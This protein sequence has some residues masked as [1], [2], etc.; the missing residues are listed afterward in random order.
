[1][2]ERGEVTGSTRGGTGERQ[3]WRRLGY[4]RGLG[5]GG[6]SEIGP[7]EIGLPE[8]ELLGGR[9]AGGARVSDAHGRRTNL[10][11][12]Q[13]KK[14]QSPVSV[15]RD[16]GDRTLFLC[17]V[18]LFPTS[19]FSS[20]TRS[21]RT[22]ARRPLDDATTAAT[23]ARPVFK[24]TRLAPASFLIRFPHARL[25]IRRCLALCLALCLVVVFVPRSSCRID[26]GLRVFQT[27]P[28]ELCVGRMTR[29]LALAVLL[30]ASISF[31]T[32][33]AACVFF[34]IQGRR[35]PGRP[36]YS[37]PAAPPPRAQP[38]QKRLASGP[39]C[40]HRPS[41]YVCARH[42]RVCPDSLGRLALVFLLR[43][44]G[45]RSRGPETRTTPGAAGTE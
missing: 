35:T 32:F 45:L 22:R 44:W 33:F 27:A 21:R 9:N 25:P 37:L 3:C 18:D 10:T 23:T 26:S 17:G 4:G 16:R 31:S 30:A 39:T 14:A 40:P 43:E 20:S 19:Q 36:R 11:L 42:S 41:P 6:L 38:Q 1:M 29:V 7:R 34:L 5:A 24:R 15:Q 28:R 13:A 2:E 12:Q 8:E